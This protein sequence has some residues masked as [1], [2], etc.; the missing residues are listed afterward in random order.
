MSQLWPEP[1][2]QPIFHPTQHSSSWQCTTIPKLITKGSVVQELQE[3][4]KKKRKKKQIEQSSETDVET[5]PSRLKSMD[6][7]GF[8]SKREGVSVKMGLAGSGG[9]GLLWNKQHRS[10]LS[11]RMYWWPSQQATKHILQPYSHYWVIDC[12]NQLD[13]GHWKL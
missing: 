1:W 8:S 4:P 11:V 13:T 2:R 12:L 10:R 3:V 6:S 9:R 5:N 7:P